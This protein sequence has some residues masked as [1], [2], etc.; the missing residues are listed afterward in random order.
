[1]YVAT[2]EEIEGLKN[3]LEEIDS[4]SLEALNI[5]MFFMMQIPGWDKIVFENDVQ[6]GKDR[7]IRITRWQDGIHFYAKVDGVDVVDSSGNQ[8]WNTYGAAYA[9]AQKWI[10]EQDGSA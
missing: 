6:V 8:K 5:R 9:S 1:M 3:R 4:N 10:S 7:K 2:K